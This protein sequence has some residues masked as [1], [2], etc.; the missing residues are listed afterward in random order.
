MTQQ[1]FQPDGVSRETADKP[2]TSLLRS[3][4][5][6]AATGWQAPDLQAVMAKEARDTF[7]R[8]LSRAR[9]DVAQ[10]LD[11]IR[12]DIEHKAHKQ[13][14]QQGQTEGYEAGYAKG[15]EQAYA[16]ARAVADQEFS[17]RQQAWDE[18]KARL[19]ADMTSGWQQLVLNLTQAL[20][21][22]ED[23]VLMD[24]T[25]LA[26]SVAERVLRAQ[27][28]LQPERVKEMVQV[29]LDALPRVTYPLTLRLHPDDIALVETMQLD[30]AGRVTLIADGDL[31]RGECRV[32]SGHS[33]T[34]FLWQEQLDGVLNAA[35][36]QLTAELSQAGDAAAHD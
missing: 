36:E 28:Q 6:G 9:A 16:E 24:I 4:D 34:A 19:Q 1:G 25:H 3:K 27:I 7:E 14:L 21:P 32:Q 33:Q 30:Q 17:A 29:A 31:Q 26:V 35:L 13:G 12:R 11:T 10:E 15:Y 22:V 5:A 2:V 8:L 18:E 20:K 23:R